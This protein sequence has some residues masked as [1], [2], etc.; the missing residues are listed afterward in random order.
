MFGYIWDFITYNVCTLLFML[1]L[2][3]AWCFTLFINMY[4]ILIEKSLLQCL[5]VTKR[6]PQYYYYYWLSLQCVQ[7]LIGSV[8]EVLYEYSV[9][10]YVKRYLLYS[11]LCLYNENIVQTTTLF[12][13]FI[14]LWYHVYNKFPRNEWEIKIFRGVIVNEEWF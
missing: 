10:K 7:Q 5:K 13:T 14:Q 1:Q 11:V 8:H 3:N 6:K 2:V 9:Y 4:L 12:D